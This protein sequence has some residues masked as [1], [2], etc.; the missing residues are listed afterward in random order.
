MRYLLR[1][2]VIPMKTIYFEFAVSWPFLKFWPWICRLSLRIYRYLWYKKICDHWDQIDQ[3]DF[4]GFGLHR[5]HQPVWESMKSWIYWIYTKL[6]ADRSWKKKTQ[7]K[8]INS[9]IFKIIIFLIFSSRSE[10]IYSRRHF[11]RGKLNFPHP[12]RKSREKKQILIELYTF[13]GVI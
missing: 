10:L 2:R 1:C 8:S 12:S 11:L 4:T 9:F 5:D 13:C 3:I 7:K 6:S